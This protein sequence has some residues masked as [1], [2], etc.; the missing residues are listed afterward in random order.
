MK[1]CGITLSVLLLT[2]CLLL[3]GCGTSD[4]DKFVGTWKADVDMTD[5]I[6]AS[7]AEDPELADYFQ[8]DSFSLTLLFTFGEDGSYQI[9]ADQDAFSDAC[10][11][12]IG[13]LSDGA[14]RYLEDMALEEGLELDAD[15]MLGLLGFSMD[16]FIEEMMDEEDLTSLLDDIEDS[17]KFEVKDGKFYTTLDETDYI[18]YEFVSDTELRFTEV[19]GEDA[20]DEELDQLLPLTLIK[21]S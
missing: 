18:A 17:G 9:T 21:Q 12:L 19:S 3:G 14:K 7:F 10:D 1:K 2:L 16:E 13:T 15:A 8:L 20:S 6:N 4:K 5:M 11:D